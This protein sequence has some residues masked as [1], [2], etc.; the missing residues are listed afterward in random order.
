MYKT[1]TIRKKRE[2][3]MKNLNKNKYF[4]FGIGRKEKGKEEGAKEEKKEEAKA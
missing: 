1:R 2:E 4:S 3:I